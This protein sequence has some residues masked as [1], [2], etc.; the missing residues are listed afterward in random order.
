MSTVLFLNGPASGHVYPTLGIVEELIAEGER[1]VYVSSEEYR[2][3]LER[4]GATFVAY[5]N[6]LRLDD[7]FLTNQNYLSLVIKIL[8]SYD[9]VLPC[10]QNLARQYRFDY[11]IH[12][13]MYGCGTIAA[14]WL[15][16]PNIATCTSFVLAE[17]LL[18]DNSGKMRLQENLMLMKEFSHLSKRI[19]TT[20]RIGRKI[21]INRIFFNEGKLNLVFTSEYFQPQSETLAPHYRFVGPILSER[22][23]RF[24]FPVVKKEKRKLIYI[25]M[26]TMFNNVRAFF[27]MCME[28]LAP[29]DVRVILAVGLRIDMEELG[30]V[31]DHITVVPFAPQLEILKETDL[32]ITHGGM[33]SVNE[34]LYY[35]VPLLIV[36]MA[37]DQ[38][39]VAGRVAEL[40]AGKTLNRETLTAEEMRDSVTEL[41][42]NESYRE[43]SARIG[44]TL[45][46]AGGQKKA[47][48]HIR[49]FK[50][51]HGIGNGMNNIL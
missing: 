17:R 12:D 7:P 19:W 13:S 11:I 43:S 10:I 29:L 6:F 24:Q 3:Q 4:I 21:E 51:D 27:R 28:A 31:P 47:M 45:R 20:F 50:R 39:I 15:G 8:S 5:E 38:P 2:E 49:A 9:I 41:L 23:E 22:H 25:S 37:A 30:D 33:N 48:E 44:V 32:F 46:E 26:G 14:D 40:G 36:P 34:A 35:G 1:V 18:A 42:G 16:I